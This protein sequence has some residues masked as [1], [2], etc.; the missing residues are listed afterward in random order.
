MKQNF[1]HN[2]ILIEESSIRKARCQWLKQAREAAGK[3]PEEVAEL[4]EIT[5]NTYYD[6]E[7]CEGDLNIVVS[8]SELS[9]ISSALGIR[10][11]FLFEG[12]SDGKQISPSQLASQIK[13][14]LEKTDMSITDFEDRVGFTVALAIENPSE[15]LNWNVDCLR[16]VSAEIG[17]SWL[18]ALPSAPN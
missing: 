2:D 12:K 15:I 13:R 11:R 5:I 17:V 4:A 9:K 3:T 16:F 10:T 6:F 8:L 14:H 1:Q 7:Q 18:D